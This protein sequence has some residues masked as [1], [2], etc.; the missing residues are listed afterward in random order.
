[1]Q[2]RRKRREHAKRRRILGGCISRT[3]SYPHDHNEVGSLG[4]CRSLLLKTHGQTLLD[5]LGTL[6]FNMIM[7]VPTLAAL[8]LLSSQ[9]NFCEFFLFLKHILRKNQPLI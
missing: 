8:G 6:L 5:T 2:T 7:W 3:S 1:M 4:Y 9:R